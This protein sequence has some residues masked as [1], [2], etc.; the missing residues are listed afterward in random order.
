MSKVVPDGRFEVF[1]CGFSR[2]RY[3][4]LEAATRC[5]VA[6]WGGY[7]IDQRTGERVV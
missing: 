6:R 4:D 7:V 1:E 5:A 3:A 2:G